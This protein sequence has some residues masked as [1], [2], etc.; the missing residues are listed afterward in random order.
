MAE[1]RTVSS[2]LAQR[3]LR[4]LIDRT[5]MGGAPAARGVWLACGGEGCESPAIL[6]PHGAQL[7]LPTAQGTAWAPVTAHCGSCS[8]Q[9]VQLYEGSGEVAH[10]PV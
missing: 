5:F 8:T 3:R 4:E 10:H 6:R 2:E 7:A 9:L 1:E